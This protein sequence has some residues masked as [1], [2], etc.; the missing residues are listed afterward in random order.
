MYRLF[1]C[2]LLITAN[3]LKAYFGKYIKIS[4]TRTHHLKPPLPLF[5][6]P[7]DRVLC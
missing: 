4:F 6:N 5:V 2:S 3:K 7:C 1:I